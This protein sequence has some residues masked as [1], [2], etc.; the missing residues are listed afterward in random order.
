VKTPMRRVRV[1]DDTWAL[2]KA[3]APG[4]NVSAWLRG[5]AADALDAATRARE[6]SRKPPPRRRSRPA[7]Q[8]YP[9]ATYSQPVLP[10]NLQASASSPD[11]SCLHARPGLSSRA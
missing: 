6:A 5:L 7:H 2:W 9:R 4:G 10:R 1:D 11:T 8:G 3:A